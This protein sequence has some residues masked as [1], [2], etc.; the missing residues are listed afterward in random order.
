MVGVGVLEELLGGS[1]TAD[2]VADGRGV[3]ENGSR[4]ENDDRHQEDDGDEERKDF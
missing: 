1:A 3:D 4:E 2:V